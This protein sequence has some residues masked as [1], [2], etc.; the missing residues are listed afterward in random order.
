MSPAPTG[1][2][3]RTLQLSWQEKTLSLPE[4]EQRRNRTPLSYLLGKPSRS[5]F[6]SRYFPYQ[7]W[8]YPARRPMTPACG[9]NS[10]TETK[11]A[12]RG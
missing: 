2:L 9:I 6:D 5:G 10:G 12:S 1:P 8:V 7:D 11:E 3:T 4:E